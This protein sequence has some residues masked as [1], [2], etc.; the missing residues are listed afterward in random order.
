VAHV[1]P[2]STFSWRS[3]GN[4]KYPAGRMVTLRTIS[5]TGHRVHELPGSQ[6]YGELPSI[7]RAVSQTGLPKM[8]FPAATGARASSSTSRARSRS[9]CR[10]R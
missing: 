7:A 9:R 1:D 3:T 4:P 2:L 5:G 6:L 10:G 8:Y